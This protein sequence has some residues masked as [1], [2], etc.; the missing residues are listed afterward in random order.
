M[1]KPEQH[2]STRVKELEKVG[3][4]DLGFK[5]FGAVAFCMVIIGYFFYK[6]YRRKEPERMK[7]KN[8]NISFSGII[9]SIYR[10]YSNH[11]VTT[12]I[13][14]NKKKLKFNMYQYSRFKKDDSI[15]KNRGKDSIYIYRKG[16]VKAYKY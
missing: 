10:D 3:N 5:I 15:V 11:G 6:D 4:R 12:L 2:I 8:L 1:R 9:D 14:K 13:L 7:E 16:E